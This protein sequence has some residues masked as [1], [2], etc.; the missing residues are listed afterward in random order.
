MKELL[1]TKW[2][3]NLG[4]V[5]GCIAAVYALIYIDV[6]LRAR[7][8]YLEGEKYWSWYQDPRLKEAALQ[9]D[10]DK[11]KEALDA[12]LS[13]GKIAQDEYQRRLDIAKFSYDRRR[14]E[15]SVKYAYIW[16]QTAVELFSPPESKWVKRA[17][18]KM[19]RAKELWKQELRAK[20]IPFEEY[21]LE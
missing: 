15:S 11:E 21:M 4:I 6:V 2:I 19:P 14:E 16:Y 9:R 10:F 18:Q 13:K 8:A 5:L 1:R 7:S 17:R 20:N 3:R 12:R